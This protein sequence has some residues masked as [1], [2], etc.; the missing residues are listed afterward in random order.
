MLSHTEENYLKAIYQLSD[1]D[2]KEVSTNA[3]S[4]YLKTRPASVSDMIRKLADKEYVHYRKYKGVKLTNKGLPISLQILRKHRLWE[5]FLVRKLGFHWDEVHEVAEQLEH[6]NSPLLVKKLDQFLGH[7]S[8]DPHGDPIPSENGVMPGKLQTP[9]SETEIN[10]EVVV[11]GVKDS[12]THFL[13]HL[14]SLNIKL[15]L[16]ILVKEKASYDGSLLL[17]SNDSTISVSKEV[18][19]NLF[20]SF[21]NSIN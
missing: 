8:F 10:Q 3:I 16:R 13:Q 5:V 11:I 15:G 12:S 14:D 17:V 2:R 6:I 1:G 7:P 9:L 19:D 21:Y 20:V 4:E 18:A